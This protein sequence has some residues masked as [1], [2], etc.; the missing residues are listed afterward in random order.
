[1]L[2]LEVPLTLLKLSQA[3]TRLRPPPHGRNPSSKLP[4]PS[5]SLSVA[6]PPKLLDPHA[7]VLV[8]QTS[9]GYACALDNLT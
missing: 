7:H 2:V 4:R 3:L 8:S 5:Q 6:E 9:D 1:M